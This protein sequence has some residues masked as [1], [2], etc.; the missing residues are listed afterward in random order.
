MDAVPTNAIAVSDSLPSIPAIFGSVLDLVGAGA[1]GLAAIIFV[2]VMIVMVFSLI[3]GKHMTDA[4]VGLTK[5]YL[6]VGAVCV[7]VSLAGT[8]V[9]NYMDTTYNLHVAVSPSLRV[10]G[11]PEP[12]IRADTV[13]VKLNEQFPVRDDIGITIMIDEIIDTIRRRDEVVAATVEKANQVVEQNNRL[14]EVLALQSGQVEA[15]RSSFETFQAGLGPATPA[16]ASNQLETVATDF[17]AISL[18]GA[19]A[20][21]VQ[22]FEPLALPEDVL[23]LQPETIR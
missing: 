10:A 22:S 19:S 20:I 4:M 3:L 12:E 23:L 15:L 21:D 11:L 8:L 13:V 7:V 17:E 18:P 2:A 6:V 14:Q 5:W 1:N 16:W 9:G